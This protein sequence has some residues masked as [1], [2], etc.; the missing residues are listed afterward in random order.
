MAIECGVIALLFLAISIIF[1]RRKQ[2]E[3][4]L[5][6]LPLMLVPVTNF[7]MELLIGRVFKIEF[8]GFGGILALLIAVAVSAAW[9]G[10]A[11]QGLKSKKKGVTYVAIAN[12]FN[13]M[14]AAIL[15]NTILIEYGNSVLLK[16]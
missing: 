13:V 8:D 6:V 15:I 7:V 5:A 12:I 4:A 14:L 11:S 9:I 10:A 1:M 2:K 3:W 16:I